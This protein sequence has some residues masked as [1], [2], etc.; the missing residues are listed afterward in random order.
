MGGG[1]GR[2]TVG[3]RE[4][5]WWV[6]KV[7]RATRYTQGKGVLWEPEGGC[8]VSGQLDAAERRLTPGGEEAGTGGYA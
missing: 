3:E 5:L 2:G 4:P 1:E 8:V 6:G 7:G